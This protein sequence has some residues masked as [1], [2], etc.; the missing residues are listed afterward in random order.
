ME[1]FHKATSFPFMATR[2]WWYT[3]SALLM[4]GSIA[5]FFAKGLN[6]SMEFT[7]GT[8]VEAS[9]P[10]AANIEAVR[11]ALEE[12]G[13]HEPTV[14][15]FGTSRDI[16]VRLAPEEKQTHRPG[17]HPRRDGIAQ[18]RSGGGHQAAEF[19]W[20]AGGH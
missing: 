20:S 6:L 17:A 4:V 1:F 9:Y 8:A 12:Q 11:T 5:L 2:R 14:Q 15:A 19:R 3:L 13:F 16:S 18:C 7:G 10:A